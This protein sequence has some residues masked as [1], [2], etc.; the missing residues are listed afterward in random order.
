MI[1]LRCHDEKVDDTPDISSV[2]VDGLINRIRNDVL[3]NRI[4]VGYQ[5]H[6]TYD[7]PRETLLD[8]PILPLYS[9]LEVN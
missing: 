5:K 9:K 4:R 3:V 6:T 1:F 2:D 7:Q 8:S